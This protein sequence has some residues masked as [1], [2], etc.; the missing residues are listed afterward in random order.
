[1]LKKYFEDD[2]YNI[3]PCGVVAFQNDSTLKIISANDYYYSTYANGNFE[4]LNI[5]KEDKNIIADLKDKNEVVYKCIVSD[6]TIRYICMHLTKYNENDILGILIDVTEQHTNLVRMKDERRCFTFALKSS[7]NIV[8]EHNVA[9]D[10]MTL[11]IPVKG[12]TELK[13]MSIPNNTEDAVYELAD[14]RDYGYLKE[15]IYNEKVENISV[16]MKL[17][18][19]KNYEWH[20]IF[21][22]FERDEKGNLKRI[23]G[24][25]TNIEDEKH[26]EK[27]LKEKIEIDPVLHVYNRNAGV[28]RINEYIKSN[29][30]SRDYALFVIDIDDFKNINDTYGHLYGDTVIAM[31]AEML[32]KATDDD[33]IVG[34]YGGDEF[35]VFL[36]SNRIA[37][38]ADRVV[39]NV[40][41][42]NISDDKRITCS[43]G[44][45]DGRIFEE[46]PNYKALFSKADKALYSTKKNGKAHWEIY[47]ENIVYDNSSHAID[48]EA[49]DAENSTEL[50]KTRDMMKV[51]LELSSSAKN[52]DDAMYKIIRYV[53]EK[54]DID[55]FQIMKVN[56][57]ED[58]IT[59]SYEWCS[60]P[61]FQNNAGKRGYYAH[62]DIEHFKE[63]FE[64][65][66]VF[67]L[68]NE[69]INGFSL[70]FQREFEKN[71]K[72]G[73]VVYNANITTG[74]SFFMFVCTRFGYENPWQIEECVELNMATK[75]MTISQSDKETENEKK[76]RKIIDYDRKTSCYTIA[77]FYEQIGRLRKFAEE[78]DEQVALLNTDFSGML[79]FNERFGQIEGDKFFE[80]FVNCIL[81]SDN[82]Y[83]IITHIDGAD[84]FYSAFRFKNLESFDKIETVNKQF[85]KMINEKYP[86]AHIIVKTGIYVLKTNEVVGVG[87]DK[88]LKAKKTVK[89]PTE[90]FCIV[91][92]KDKHENS[93][94]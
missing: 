32:N 40:C 6:G 1:M 61:K 7:K 41:K 49:E 93:C 14:K 80:E 58:L 28:E 62:S 88:A 39:D 15:N 36:K 10:N 90:S 73:E 44:V 5:C 85:S 34:R 11:Y 38:N 94:C 74:D 26:H 69:K 71:K 33:A 29:P 72:N 65:Y 3:M 25:I 92:D 45:A 60:D 46:V 89:N 64:K 63:F 83:N 70:K 50:F 68:S 87:L 59:I 37:E 18:G 84:I 22:N 13:K 56:T 91:Y 19:N 81:S 30:E 77:K 78:K 79:D 8:F 20:R 82:D 12:Q 55:W 31:V 43:V 23:F 16:R 54:F 57:K 76:L 86:G 9:D 42:I 53:A 4:S 66:P 47:N 67:I 17:P 51:F 27:E 52:S 2:S 75:L 48:Y 35:F 21:R 24:T